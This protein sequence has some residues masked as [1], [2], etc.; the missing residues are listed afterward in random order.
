MM[1]PFEQTTLGKVLRRYGLNSIT[2]I[3]LQWWFRQKIA[4]K[5]W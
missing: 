2:D 4:H 3:I 5:S 1:I